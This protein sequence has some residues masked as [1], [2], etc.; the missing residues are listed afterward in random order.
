MLNRKM[1]KLVSVAMTL[2]VVVLCGVRLAAAQPIA[3]PANQPPQAAT[4]AA[5]VLGPPE[6]DGPVVVRASFEFHNIDEISEEK[7][8]FEFTD[9]LTLRWHDKRPAFDPAVVGVS[10]KIY[11]GDY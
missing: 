3:E 7:E 6:D 9:V 10:E 1:N 11:Q 8:T 2:V 5:F 4:S